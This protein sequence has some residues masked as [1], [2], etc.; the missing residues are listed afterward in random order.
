MECLNNFFKIKLND[1]I[2]YFFKIKN[3]WNPQTKNFNNIFL[4]LKINGIHKEN[5]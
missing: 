3:Q 1:S 4:K 5:F 2:K